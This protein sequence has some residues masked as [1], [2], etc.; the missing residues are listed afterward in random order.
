MLAVISVT[1]LLHYF[2]FKEPWRLRIK[3]NVDI[4]YKRKV[5]YKDFLNG[6]LFVYTH[7]CEVLLTENGLFHSIMDSVSA[8]SYPLQTDNVFE[9]I[10]ITAGGKPLLKRRGCRQC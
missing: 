8:A 5:Q 9:F 7:I 2:Y 4:F 10:N 1:I 3:K 6:Y